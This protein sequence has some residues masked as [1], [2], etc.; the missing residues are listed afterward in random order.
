MFRL[1]TYI[2]LKPKPFTFPNPAAAPIGRHTLEYYG[3]LGIQINEVYGM[4]ESTG[5]STVSTNMC[6]QWGYR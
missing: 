6:H 1:H 2:Y 4:S 3:S 5:G